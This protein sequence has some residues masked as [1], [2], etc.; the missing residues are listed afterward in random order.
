MTSTS[1][2][3]S[4]RLTSDEI[5]STKWSS[6]FRRSRAMPGEGI[7]GEGIRRWDLLPWAG[8]NE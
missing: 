4:P 3:A 6:G 7:L 8:R 2:R 1:G 5:R